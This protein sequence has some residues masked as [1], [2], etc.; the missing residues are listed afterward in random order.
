[1]TDTTNT[2]APAGA[3][4]LPGLGCLF[5]EIASQLM[6]ARQAL[7]DD[8]GETTVLAIAGL[9]GKLGWMA[10]H[11]AS[12]AGDPLTYSVAGGDPV[13]WLLA[14]R[15]RELLTGKP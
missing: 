7:Y 11:G 14:P 8:Q 1:M 5:G 13:E 9:L 10:D 3:D 12:L 6:T 4:L 15:T 2:A